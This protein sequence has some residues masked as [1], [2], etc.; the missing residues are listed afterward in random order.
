MVI[1]NA[2]VLSIFNLSEYA[3]CDHITTVGSLNDLGQI[4]LMHQ[5]MERTSTIVM[6]IIFLHF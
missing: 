1:S 4:Y 5:C 3:L 2:V 6:D